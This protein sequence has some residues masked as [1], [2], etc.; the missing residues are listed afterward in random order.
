MKIRGFLL[1]ILIL[2]IAVFF[3]KI[4]PQKPESIPQP[5]GD[6]KTR[7]SEKEPELALSY[8]IPK[9][10][11]SIGAYDD[12]KATEEVGEDVIPVKYNPMSKPLYSP[13]T[14]IPSKKDIEEEIRLREEQRKTYMQLIAERDSQSLAMKKVVS[15][16]FKPQRG[17]EIPSA[18]KAGDVKTKRP[19]PPSITKSA[20]S[21]NRYIRGI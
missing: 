16:S 17:Q 11:I 10:T 8:A 7:I 21:I 15:V 13:N 14:V 5:I 2:L 1:V 4:S 18:M 6:P 3:I 19:T 12:G 9:N 20:G